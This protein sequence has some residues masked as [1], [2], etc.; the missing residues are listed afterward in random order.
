M[1]NF[2]Q[3]R[4]S[5]DDFDNPDNTA[6]QVAQHEDFAQEPDP[7]QH[8]HPN[9]FDDDEHVR[10]QEDRQKDGENA[11]SG[12]ADDEVGRAQESDDQLADDAVDAADVTDPEGAANGTDRDGTAEYGADPETA[13]RG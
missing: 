9:E 6:E 8:S 4:E 7:K 11:N 10:A 2:T 5:A 3:S 1:T 12:G 13:G